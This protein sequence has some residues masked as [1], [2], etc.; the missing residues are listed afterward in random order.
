MPA[1]RAKKPEPHVSDREPHQLA[2]EPFV[3]LEK[4]VAPHETRAPGLR[5]DVTAWWLAELGPRNRTTAFDAGDE[6][7]YLRLIDDLKR[8]VLDARERADPRAGGPRP[9]RAR[10]GERTDDGPAAASSAPVV[11]RARETPTPTGDELPELASGPFARLA[12]VIEKYYPRCPGLRRDV[13]QW[14][15]DEVMPGPVRFERSLHD[16]FEHI[17][18]EL[19]GVMAALAPADA[20]VRETPVVRRPTKVIPDDEVEVVPEVRRGPLTARPE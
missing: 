6:A 14:W 9:L 5:A 2:W 16:V 20:P 7:I 13:R 3:S 11:R 19:L 1:A 10:P 12:R 18:V 17:R 8:H 15:L 4:V